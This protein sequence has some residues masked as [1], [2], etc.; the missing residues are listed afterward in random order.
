[1]S[2]WGN[3]DS[4]LK[5]KGISRKELS[6]MINVKEITIHKAIERDSV[7]SADTALKIAKALNVSLEYLLD[8]ETI[9][10]HDSN[11]DFDEIQ[12]ATKLYRKYNIILNEL[13][14]LSQKELTA[15]SQLVK[16][17]SK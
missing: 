16:T 3:V 15:V 1:M 4:E 5:F 11:V 2:F 10:Q 13:E 12:K 8:M 6:Y 14:H 7:P 17:L 9:T